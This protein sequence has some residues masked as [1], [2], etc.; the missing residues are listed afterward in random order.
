MNPTPADYRQVIDLFLAW[1]ESSTEHQQPRD[2]NLLVKATVAAYRLRAQE[3]EATSIRPALVYAES[4]GR[5]EAE[6]L[7]EVYADNQDPSAPVDLASFTDSAIF[8][9]LANLIE[10]GEIDPENYSE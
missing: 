10:I 1:F 4:I 7:L 8:R 3:P 2:A 9:N 5:D 6:Q